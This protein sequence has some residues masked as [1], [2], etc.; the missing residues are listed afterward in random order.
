VVGPRITAENPGVAS[1]VSE[2]RPSPP[3][4]TAAAHRTSPTRDDA[5][6]DVTHVGPSVGR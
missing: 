5:G 2:F 6:G 1:N 3:D 4:G